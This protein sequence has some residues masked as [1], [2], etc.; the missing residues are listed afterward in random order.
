MGDLAFDVVIY[1]VLTLVAIVCLYPVVYV[2]SVSL[3]SVKAVETHSVWLWPVGLSFNSYELLYLHPSLGR[4]YLNTVVYTALGTTYSLTLTIFGGF[5]LSRRRLIGRNL[6]MFLI[7]FTM[8]FSGG[9]I[10]TFLVVRD[11]GM[12]NSWLALIIPCA[13]SP[14]YLIIMRTSM[15]EIPPSLEESATIDGA[16]DIAVLFRIV[17]PMSIPVVSTIGL[18]YAVGKWNDYFNAL[19][20]LSKTE[21]YPVQLIIRNLLITLTDN[22]VNTKVNQGSQVSSFTPQAFKSAVV[23]VTML[24]IMM[25]YPFIQKYF[26]KGVMVGAIK[27]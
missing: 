4:C 13:V 18:F 5:A 19:I 24:P 21:L 11:L 3:S 12:Y 25:V 16:N 8:L 20:Y 26:V 7:A 1:V 27:G 15:Q 23:V 14:W 2:I 22:L 17:M 10:P 6:F 9:L